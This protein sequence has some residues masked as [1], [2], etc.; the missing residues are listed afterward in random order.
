MFFRVGITAS[1]HTTGTPFVMLHLRIMINVIGIHVGA[2]SH[3]RD[4]FESFPTG[5]G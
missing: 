3:L 2:N 4:T 1:I 5:H